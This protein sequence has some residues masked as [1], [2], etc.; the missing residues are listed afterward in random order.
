M[1]WQEAHAYVMR[2]LYIVQA[3]SSANHCFE[4]GD[5]RPSHFSEE[6]C[7][8][9]SAHA[10]VMRWQEGDY[11]NCALYKRPLRRII[12]SEEATRDRRTFRRNGAV[13]VL[14]MRMSCD[15]KKAIAPTAHCT[16]ALFGESLFRRRRQRPSHCSG[17][18]V[19]S[20][21]CTCVCH[22]MA[23]RRLRQLRIV[24]APSSAN[25]FSEEA[26]GGRRTFPE[27][28]CGRSSA[29]AYVMRWQEGSYTNCALYKR[30]LRRI[31]VSEEATRGRRTVREE[32][33]G[34]SSA[35]AY[36]MRWQE[37]SYT[38]CALY[39]RPLRRIIVSEE[40]TRGRRTVREEWCG[41]SSAHA[42][43][44]RWREGSY[45]NRAL[46]KR[47][48]RR[49]IV[50]EEATRGRRIVR[51]E[52]CGRSSAHAYV[53][54]WREGVTP[55][56]HCTSAL[57]GESLFRRRRPEAVALFGRNGA[58]EVLHMRMSSMAGR[59]TPIV[60][61]TSGS[62]IVSKEATGDLARR[63]R[64]S[65]A[66]ACHAMAGR[67]GIYKRQ[68]LFRRRHCTSALFGESLY[69]RFGDSFFERG[70]WRPSHFSGGMMRSKFCTCVCHAMARRQL[71][72]LC[73]VQAP[74]SA[75]HCF[76]GGDQRPSHF[77]GGMVRSKFCTCVC[78]AMARRRLR[79]LRIV[80]AP[81][82]ANHRFGGGDQRPS[83]CSG[84]MVRSK[85]CTC[86][87]HAMERRQ[88]RQLRI[89][90]A[91]SSANHC[92]EGGDQRPSHFSGG[93]VRSKFC[94]CVCHAICANCALYK[95]PLRRII[96]S[97]EATRDRRT[98]REEWCGRSSAHAYV[99]RWREGSYTNRALYKRPLRRIIVSEEATRGRRTVREEW[100]GRS[101]AHAYVM[102]WREGS[103]TN[104]AL[105]K[106]PLSF[107][108]RGV[109][110]PSHFSG[111]MM[112]SKFCTCV[113][114]A[115]ARRRLRQLY[116]VQA[117]SSANHCFGGGDQRP[118][119][120][121]G[122]MVRSKFCTCVCHA[123]ERR[124]LRQLCIVQAPSSATHFFERGVW[125]PSHFS[126]GAVRICSSR[127]RFSSMGVG[128]PVRRS[129]AF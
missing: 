36:V 57:F 26:T 15:G 82:S 13:E 20:K 27:E 83:H 24:Q 100:C 66:H 67:I 79:Q 122:G 97:K 80:Q 5:W 7:G 11:A 21:F 28:W 113:C 118:S 50:S 106:R 123:M 17:G 23:R 84:G 98:F 93:M 58:V 78:H 45:T 68:S 38:N 43:V 91:P 44:M 108:E 95:R 41:R 16:S 101:S 109:W 115:M 53:M 30:P 55:I 103:Y 119:H 25:H 48:L 96:V 65:S 31:I 22:A 92:F 86:V 59:V 76:G 104:R 107:F 40:A 3:P 112:R 102:R 35:H 74:S 8:R 94:T 29:H 2:Q 127:R 39:K 73:I 19:R 46:C 61:C 47:P 54:R 72:Q 34:R 18:M 124:R 9:S 85:F 62:I 116:I 51:E 89:V 105:Y 117:P 126:G 52:W 114:H 12:V 70:D 14:H 77:S 10:Y 125:V 88:L 42:Y 121:S 90:Q 75:N 129:C 33:C 6:W 1:I 69:K 32:W 71:R 111:G 63:M 81:S 37:G 4:G 49:I 120:F 87:C 110:R 60:H 56:V 64:R 128:A 99:M